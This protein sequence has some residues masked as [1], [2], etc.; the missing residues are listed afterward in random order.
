MRLRCCAAQLPRKR[1]ARVLASARSSGRTTQQRHGSASASPIRAGPLSQGGR[2]LAWCDR[3]SCR[4]AE[5]GR[6]RRTNEPL[7]ASP[8]N[9][10]VQSGAA[11][12][13]IGLARGDSAASKGAAAERGRRG[14]VSRCRASNVSL[15][16]PPKVREIGSLSMEG[17]LDRRNRRRFHGRRRG[18]DR[19]GREIHE[20]GVRGSVAS[21]AAGGKCP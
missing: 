9:L 10:G 2:S 16:R 3:G 21:A 12:R 17:A 7:W 19:A 4:V 18:G 11:R 15:A 1:P 14:V 20:R 6:R 5:V 8:L 13:F